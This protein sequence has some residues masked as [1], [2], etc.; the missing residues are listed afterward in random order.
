VAGADAGAILAYLSVAPGPSPS[1]S[2]GAGGTDG[3]EEEL[4]MDT[5][6]EERAAMQDYF[7]LLGI[8]VN[9]ETALMKRAALA[10]KRDESRGPAV[11][12]EYHTTNR[13]GTVVIRQR[14]SGGALDYHEDTGETFWTEPILYPEDAR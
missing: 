13:E 9:P 3:E 7:Q 5:T 11:T 4:A 2:P 6:A 14:F 10:K 12:G 1:P 8:P